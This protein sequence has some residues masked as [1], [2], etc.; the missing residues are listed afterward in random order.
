MTTEAGKSS[1]HGRLLRLLKRLGE[2]LRGN[3]LNRRDEFECI[4]Q[5]AHEITRHDPHAL[6]SLVKL[7]GRST[8]ARA[9]TAVLCHPQDAYRIR[10]E[11]VMVG[12]IEP[13][14][15]DGRSFHTLKRKVTTQRTLRL[16]EDL[17]LPRPWHRGRIVLS[18]C[19]LRVGGKWGEWQQDSTNHRVELWIPLGIGWVSGG[20]HSLTAG[21]VHAAGVVRPDAAYDIS[22][23]YDHVTCDGS[24]YK[25]T[26]DGSVIER[27][28]D[29][30]LAAIFEI[31]RLMRQHGIGY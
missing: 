2:R 29:F 15:N 27:V 1:Q 14:T 5:I 19:G 31:G 6:P 24:V 3:R 28:A 25:R 30:E 18:L 20:N 11:L 13:V 8:Q 12:S 22:D 16:G 17:V 26:H 4:L 7:V 21:I 10:Q 9:M 23:V